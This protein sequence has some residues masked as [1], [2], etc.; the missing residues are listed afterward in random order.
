MKFTVNENC[1]ACGLCTGICPEVFSLDSGDDIM[2]L[3]SMTPF[4]YRTTPEAEAKLA[5]LSRIDLTA[6]VEYFIYRKVTE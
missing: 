2:K 6:D 4:S 5:S 1:I 3:Y